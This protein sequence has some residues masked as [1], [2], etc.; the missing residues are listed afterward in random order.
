[1]KHR[2]FFFILCILCLCP[3]TAFAAIE[4]S[5]DVK[6]EVGQNFK[7]ELPDPSRG[8]IDQT[9]WA[10]N[11]NKIRFVSSTQNDEAYVWI[12]ADKYFEGEATVEC[13]YTCAWYDDNIGGT[14]GDTYLRTYHI[15]CKQPERLC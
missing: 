14:R 1:M 2:L 13:L 8:Y 3:K 7:L 9:R 10:N 15:T 6:I 11:T 4:T 12:V 5:E